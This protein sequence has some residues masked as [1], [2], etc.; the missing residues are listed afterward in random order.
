VSGALVYGGITDVGQR[1]IGSLTYSLTGDDE[2]VDRLVTLLHAVTDVVEHLPEDFAA[3]AEDLTPTPSD[4]S[5]VDVSD[6]QT[7]EREAGR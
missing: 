1:P 3:P 6:R 7:D 2:R 5:V 4:A